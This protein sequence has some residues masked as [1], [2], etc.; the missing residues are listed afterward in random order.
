MNRVRASEAPLDLPTATPWSEP[1]FTARSMR[2]SKSEFSAA[3][4]PLGLGITT[5]GLNALVKAPRKT[6]QIA[7]NPPLTATKPLSHSSRLI[8]AEAARTEDSCCGVEVFLPTLGILGRRSGNK[9]H[10]HL[11]PVIV[12][13]VIHALGMDWRC[14]EKRKTRD[15]R[16][17]DRRET[18]HEETSRRKNYRNGLLSVNLNCVKK[19]WAPRK[20]RSAHARF[21]L[22][23]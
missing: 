23:L 15:S 22:G 13:I 9:I 17:K 11:W 20:N 2:P 21:N 19:E 7:L 8:H 16:K 18:I 10:I 4:T 14:H 12:S 6:P 3:P 1:A 5:P